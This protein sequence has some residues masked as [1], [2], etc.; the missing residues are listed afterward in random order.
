MTGFKSSL[1]VLAILPGLMLLPALEGAQAQQSHGVPASASSA[2][3]SDAK[4]S[5]QSPQESFALRQ[6]INLVLVPVVVRDKKGKP[7]GSLTREDFRILDDGKPQTISTFSLEANPT[8]KAAEDASA[9]GKA[10]T[11]AIAGANPLHYFAYLFDDVHLKAG[12]LMQVSAAAQKHLASGMGPQD[13]AAVFTTSGDVSTEFTG[14]TAELSQAMNKIKPGFSGPATPCPYMNYLLAQRIVYES[15]SGREFGTGSTPLWDAATT[16]T[17]NCLFNGAAPTIED[18]RRAALSAARREK[19]IGDANTRRSLLAVQLEVRRLAAMPGSRTLIL[20]SPGFLSGD[21][22]SEQDAIIDLATKEKVVVNA[23]DSR[24][25]YTGVAGADDAGGSSTLEVR[26]TEA[27]YIREA[28]T[29]QSGIMAELAYGTGG[30]L[31]RDSND[32]A[33]GFD[34]L[35]TVP[36]YIYELGFSPTDLNHPGRYHT[37]KIELAQKRGWSVQA[38][39]GYSEISGGN[40]PEKQITGELEEALFSKDQVQSFPIALQTAYSNKDEAHR[41]FSVT[42]HIDLGAIHLRRANSTSVDNLTLVC[43][44][45]DI[46]GN[47]LQGKK[48][49]LSLHLSDDVLNR[50]TSGLNV[51]TTFE[52]APGAYMIRVVVLDSG[53]GL[54][55]TAN[56]SGIIH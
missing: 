30:D 23:L 2:P 45:F 33:G 24:G 43:G 53:S 29:A 4:T 39:R 7:V 35:G 13:R 18:A 38:R 5:K 28:M 9:L 55:S 11:G 48:K 22:H 12:D 10:L 49:E 32:L 16:D 36:E 26:Q 54:L 20:V 52:V 27:P 47:Y 17:L 51:A 37:L 41:E 50:I 8:G 56:G 3:A 15:G 40:A 31:F 14:D 34:E 42:T 21:D 46:N 6:Q 1:L 25:L 19:Q 44:L